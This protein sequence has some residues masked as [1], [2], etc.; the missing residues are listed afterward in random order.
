[1]LCQSLLYSKVNQ[2]CVYLYTIFF[3]FPSHLG[4][5]R[6]LSRVPCAIQQVLI[7]H[8]HVRLSAIPWTIQSMEFSWSEYWSGQL[9]ASPGDLPS[10]GI[11]PGSPALQADSLPTELSGKPKFSLV[12]YFI[13]HS[14]YIYLNPNLP[15]RPTSSSL[16]GVH[17]VVLYIC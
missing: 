7:V 4:R 17:M 15:I 2:Q 9:F 12:I 10:P 14:T 13:H 3:G 8:G 16:L 6:P 5:H 11:K 1:M